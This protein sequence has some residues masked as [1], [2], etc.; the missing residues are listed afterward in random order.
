MENG[1][2]KGGAISYSQ[3]HFCRYKDGEPTERYKRP[4]LAGYVFRRLLAISLELWTLLL[5]L[6]TV[7]KVIRQFE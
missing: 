2:R 4:M 1:G 6:L 3:F 5:A 7:H